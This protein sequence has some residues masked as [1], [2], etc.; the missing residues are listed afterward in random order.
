MDATSKIDLFMITSPN[1]DQNGIVDLG[2]HSSSSPL[3]TLDYFN[4]TVLGSDT[5]TAQGT[6]GLRI[7]NGVSSTGINIKNNILVVLTTSLWAA[8]LRSISTVT[9]T[10]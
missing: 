9:S 8:A 10:V 2:V 4:N 6:V 7:E 5:N 3:Q 1:T